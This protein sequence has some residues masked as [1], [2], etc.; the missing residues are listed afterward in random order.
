MKVGSQN[1]ESKIIAEPTR[2]L[3]VVVSV[4]VVRGTDSSY[5]RL[6]LDGLEG[7]PYKP[8]HKVQLFGGVPLNLKKLL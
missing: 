7:W 5:I 6:V 4:H 8:L 1:N 2:K 3:R